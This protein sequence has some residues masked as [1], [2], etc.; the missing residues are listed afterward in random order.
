M[1][2]TIALE[3]QRGNAHERGAL[4]QRVCIGDIRVDLTC[5]DP[6]IDISV[7]QTT[8]RFLVDGG[9]ADATV[10]TSRGDLRQPVAP[11]CAHGRVR[12]AAVYQ[13][14]SGRLT[15]GNVDAGI[16]AGQVDPDVSDADPLAQSA[17]LV[18]V[19]SLRLQG[20]R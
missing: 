16:T 3:T 5:G 13:E 18:S 7:C 12:S 11:G 14:P 19:P 15:N 17:S 10:C 8:R 6:S 4:R 2:Q 20:N 1:L 9:R